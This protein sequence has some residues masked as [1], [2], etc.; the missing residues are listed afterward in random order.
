MHH[1]KPGHHRRDRGSDAV[2]ACMGTREHKRGSEPPPPV[3]R[4]VEN[5]RT[6]LRLR[7]ASGPIDADRVQAVA[8]AIDAAATE[9]ERV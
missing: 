1:H 8:A 2:E 4:A 6:A 5:L 9:A 3:L 7:L